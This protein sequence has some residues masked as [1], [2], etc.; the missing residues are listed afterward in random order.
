MT[1]A[2]KVGKRKP[3]T[4]A[5]VINKAEKRGSF[6]LTEINQSSCWAT[7]AVGEKVSTRT[8]TFNLAAKKP[9]LWL[10][11]SAANLPKQTDRVEGALY[12]DLDNS[13]LYDAGMDFYSAVKSGDFVGAR[14]ALAR[15]DTFWDKRNKAVA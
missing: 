14:E 5:S 12:E 9:Q 11:P 6:T 15:V 8:E 1:S 2:K 3:P 13:N 4:W 10:N 7:C